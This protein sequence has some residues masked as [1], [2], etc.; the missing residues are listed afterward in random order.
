MVFRVPMWKAALD[1]YM[2]AQG[3]STPVKEIVE[4]KSFH[5]PLGGFV[6]VANVGLDNNWLHHPMALANLYGF[7]RLAWNPEL[8]SEQIV[9]EWTRL[10]FG[11]DPHVVAVV[12]ALQ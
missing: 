7:G 4:G 1:T 8:S 3:R 10:T 5:Q 12:D 11:N 2:R 9:D 6:G